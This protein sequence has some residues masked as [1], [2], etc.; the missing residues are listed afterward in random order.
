MI[1]NKSNVS[2][3]LKPCSHD[4]IEL[5]IGDKNI[6]GNLNF[7]KF[8]NLKILSCNSNHI[9]CLSN[10]Q[11]SLTKLYCNS[12]QITSLDNLPNSLTELCCQITNFEKIKI[13]YPKLI[14]KC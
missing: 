14:I 13:A 8:K 5:N 3:M 10:L 12:N 9:S 2:K 4:I 11:N 7:I 1:S 6:N